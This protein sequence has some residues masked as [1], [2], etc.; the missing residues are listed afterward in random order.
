MSEA[1]PLAEIDAALAAGDHR[2]AFA[3]MR[4]SL[5]YPQGLA[6]WRALLGRFSRT[7]EGIAGGELADKVR[8]VAN[9]RAADHVQALY[10]LGYELIEHDLPEI[11]ATFLARACEVAPG[12]PGL[13]SELC[14]ALE[15]AN[16]NAEA[17]QWL[18]SSASALAESFVLR[19]L[20]A[21]NALMTGDLGRARAQVATLTRPADEN[22]RAMVHRMRGVL[23]R[24]EAVAT[25][26]PLDPRDLRGWHFVLNGGLL[27]HVSPHGFD[28]GMNG[29]YA[30]RQ[31]PEAMCHE[32]LVRLRHV[33]IGLDLQL[34]SVLT[35]RDPD[36]AALGAATAKF[37]GLPARPFG[38]VL[39]APGLVVVY[40][41][42][43]LRDED[44]AD[45][46]SHRPGQVLWTHAS[47]WTRDQPLAGDIVTYL[48][49]VNASPWGERL[50]FDPQH[51]GARRMPRDP[52][53]TEVLADRVLAAQPDDG[54]L[55]DL[56]DL[57]RLARAVERLSGDHA[58]G[59]FRSYG[60]R[61]RQW[62]G[63]PV[64]SNR[65]L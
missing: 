20:L 47:E 31:D 52:A 39:D 53:P 16:L 35:L 18:E 28:E 37:L 36:S 51:G 50:A 63:G 1:P 3:A 13:L 22:E 17:V 4:W 23:A 41:L 49:Q 26:T 48:Y 42:A 55:A 43:N 2:A 5:H 21:W 11:A 64:P 30:F 27:L 10:D 6:H 56:D 38:E 34:T 29:R 62:S 32:A 14:A 46:Q 7:C 24:A 12:H 8:V 33:T 25:S 54:G 65:F 19:Y 40:D 45:L 15:R 59:A 60:P 9:E 58:A 57:D 44:V 61:R